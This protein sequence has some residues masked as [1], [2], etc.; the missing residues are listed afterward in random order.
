MPTMRCIMLRA[1]GAS[2]CT[3]PKLSNAY[4]PSKC[5]SVKSMPSWSWAFVCAMG[6][7]L[8]THRERPH[9]DGSRSNCVAFGVSLHVWRAWMGLLEKE[10]CDVMPH[11]GG[12]GWHP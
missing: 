10:E 3:L 6:R 7:S 11:Q 9:A 5:V 12:P 2:S 1:P 8:T 4:W